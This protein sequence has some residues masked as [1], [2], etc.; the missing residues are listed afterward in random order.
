MSKLLKVVL[1]ITLVIN[2]W[3]VLLATDVC[4][5]ILML[6]SFVPVAIFFKVVGYLNFAVMCYVF[7]KVLQHGKKNRLEEAGADTGVQKESS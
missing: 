3:A 4:Y 2:G 6:M 1:C 5:M 7:N